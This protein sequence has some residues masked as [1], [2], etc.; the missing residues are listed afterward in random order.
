MR[1]PI[2]IAAALGAAACTSD[3]SPVDPAPRCGDATVD[4]GEV[5]DDGVNDRLGGG[6]MPG[7]TAFDD[8][9][10]LFAAPMHEV[11]LAIDPAM[12]EALRHEVKSR[13]AVFGGADCRTHP[14][15]NPYTWY[16]ADLTLD[17]VS[18]PAVAVRKKGHLGS[19]STLRPSLKLDL[20][21]L[22]A[23]RVH[24]GLESF[25]LNN[26]KQ[27]ASLVRTC[28]A[29]QAFA[30]AGVPAPRCTHAHVTVNGEDQGV[31]T[32]LEE[33]DHDF[34]ARRFADATG[35]LYE[36][37]ASD[38]RAEFVGGFERE[39]NADDP[40]RA[41]LDRVMT[42]LA[43]PDDALEA[44]LA[45]LLDLDGF[46]RFWAAETLVWHRDGYSGN[47]NNFF[48]YAD[49]GAGGRFRFL[50][51]GADATLQADTRAAVP[52]SVMAYS[53]LTH[54][55]YAIPAA[56]DRYHAA[57]DAL[58]AEAW[59]PA[60]LVARARAIGAAAEPLL[61]DAQR[62]PRAAA[63]AEV[64]AVITG[65][66]DVIAAARASG[67]PP[68]TEPMR[69]LPCRVEVGTASGTFSTRWGTIAADA[70]ASGTGTFTLTVGATT[71]ATTRI[72]ARAGTTAT[73][74]P[75]VQ[76][77]GE[78]ATR[79]YT[80]TVP[81]PD[82]VWFDPFAV[83]GDYPLTS[84][85]L[86]ISIVEQDLT[87]MPIATLRRFELGEGTW[88]FTAVGTGAS[89]PVTGTFTGRLYEVP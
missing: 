51:W 37:T 43:G 81:F 19:Q 21:K 86:S 18:L 72:G 78:T 87:Q 54:R 76:V 66:A 50:P 70:F 7:C 71:T 35:N 10:D 32:F 48:L 31:Y 61:A 53:A 33:V 4:T 74:T 56:R 69:A 6:C 8:S 9:D 55:L 27:D 16:E 63:A 14:I 49:P 41:D 58:L 2:A 68:W 80:M 39:N 89:D 62:A 75:R 83:V 57:L 29:Y 85:P 36:G 28:V 25:A 34:L 15:A 5:C 67:P 84:P 73:V 13:H 20:D 44:A 59:D 45:P 26:N 3:D 42:A 88:T 77:L 65:R 11:A 1:V 17:G 23:G 60:A 46:F 24:R 52:D 47:A 12:W 40:S 30:A 82:A 22:V 64:E 38:F 79:R